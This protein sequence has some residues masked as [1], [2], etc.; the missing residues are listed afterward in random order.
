MGDPLVAF[1]RHPGHC[2]PEQGLA[3]E[4]TANKGESTTRWP[5]SLDM[6]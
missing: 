6:F 1:H 2:V 3:G 5:Q 4:R